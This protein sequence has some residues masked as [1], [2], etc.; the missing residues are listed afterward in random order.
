M[1]HTS[2]RIDEEI[3]EKIVKL[4]DKDKRSVNSE[5]IFILEKFL[6]EK[7]EKKND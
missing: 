4:A 5:I 2:I 1:V 3:Y 7:E 6:K